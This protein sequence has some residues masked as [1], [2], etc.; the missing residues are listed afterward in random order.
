MAKRCELRWDMPTVRLES[1]GADS[2][3]V[4][5]LGL[6]RDEVSAVDKVLADNHLQLVKQLKALYLEVTGDAKGKDE[7]SP[8]SLMREIAEKSRKE[9]VKRAFARLSRERAGLQPAPATL[10]GTTAVERMYRMLTSTGDGVERA[11]GQQIGPDL[12]RRYRDVR[13]GF[14]SRLVSRHGCP[15]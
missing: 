13:N 15:K 9:D 7:L 6:S 4:K 5:E 8:S 12:A 1:P 3:A 11:M 2:K 14:S 10:A